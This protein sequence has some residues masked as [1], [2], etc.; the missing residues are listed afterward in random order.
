MNMQKLAHT[1]CAEMGNAD[2]FPS[3]PLWIVG[4][5]LVVTGSVGDLLSFGFAPMSLLAPLGA[6]TLV[7]NMIIAPCFLSETLTKRDVV[8]TLVIFAGTLLCVLFGSKEEKSYTIDELLALYSNV[9]F[10]VFAIVFCLL[11]IIV[12]F[13]L[14]QISLREH[15]KLETIWDVRF[16]SFAYPCMGGTFG[17]MSVLF[18]KSCTEIAKMTI[19]GDNQFAHFFAYVEIIGLLVCVFLQMKLLNMGLE[20]ADALFIVP[21]YQVFWVVMSVVAGMIYFQDYTDMDWTAM[22]C[23]IIGVVITL[24]GVYFLTQRVSKPKDV[25][26]GDGSLPNSSLKS[27]DAKARILNRQRASSFLLGFS[28]SLREPDLVSE[29]QVPLFVVSL[30]PSASKDIEETFNAITG[31]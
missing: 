15:N 31:L 24:L 14:K 27:L 20:K 11:M 26:S 22:F 6:M 28:A 23:F 10:I 18:A 19:A 17:A 2:S 21:V 7:L 9:P 12:Y 30:P 8:Y 5:T 25:D 16:Q 29:A 4:I 3:H 1:R 13:L